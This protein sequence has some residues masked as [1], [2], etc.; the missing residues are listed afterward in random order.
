MQ[1]V[2][3][4]EANSCTQFETVSTMHIADIRNQHAH[5]YNMSLKRECHDIFRCYNA[6]LSRSQALS[7][8]NLKRHIV[9]KIVFCM[10]LAAASFVFPLCWL[11]SFT[12]ICT[13]LGLNRFVL[14]I[15]WNHI[16]VL[17]LSSFNLELLK[18]L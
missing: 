14:H 4:S 12:L 11:L 13:Y 18:M 16:M 5:P 7:F 17:V 8:L 3:S 10:Y 2:T 6:I 15:L 9:Y 1:Q